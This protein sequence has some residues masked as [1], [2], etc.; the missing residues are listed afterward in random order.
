MSTSP[1]MPSLPMHVMVAIGIN[2]HS[3]RL[4]EA[5]ARLAQGLNATLLAVHIHPPGIAGSLYETNLEWHF[6]LARA[7][8]ADTDVI[9]GADVAATLVQHAQQRGVTHLVLGQSDVTRWH[10]IRQGSIVNRLLREIARQG[11]AIDLYI[12]TGS[13]RF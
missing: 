2:P 12:V 6:E 10:E 7:L 11:A 9:E 8:G 13:N 3:Q 5:A 1:S 4:L